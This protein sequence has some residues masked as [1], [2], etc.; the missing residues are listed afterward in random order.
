M[1][2]AG[3]AELS[4]ADRGVAL[5]E[6]G[7]GLADFYQ[8]TLALRVYGPQVVGD[9]RRE[10]IL[11]DVQESL[12]ALLAASEVDWDIQ[13]DPPRWFWIDRDRITYATATVQTRAPEDVIELRTLVATAVASSGLKGAGVDVMEQALHVVGSRRVEASPLAGGS[14]PFG[15]I[16]V[17]ATGLMDRGTLWRIAETVADDVEGVRTSVYEMTQQQRRT[18]RN[19]ALA[20]FAFG[21][22]FG[23]VVYIGVIPYYSSWTWQNVIHYLRVSM[24]EKIEQVSLK[25]HSDSR[26]GDAIYRIN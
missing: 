24:I 7:A 12:S 26:V 2:V 25:F 19:R 3:D 17:E 9:P 18:V 15:E 4:S 21:A 13:E 6:F 10:D 1:D 20:W 23:I 5:A 14:E 8:Q 11:D 22:L 16:D